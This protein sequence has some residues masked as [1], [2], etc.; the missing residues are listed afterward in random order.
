MTKVIPLTPGRIIHFHASEHDGIARLNGQPLPAMIAGIHNDRLVNLSVCD[1]YGNWQPRSSV[2]F[3]QPGD[4]K[5]DHAHATWMEYQIGQAAKTEQLEQQLQG[6][7]GPFAETDGASASETG[8]VG[9]S[10]EGDTTGA[11][12][13]TDDDTNASEGAKEPQA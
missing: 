7:N 5:P 10:N 1:A 12:E 13:A 9:A 3:V 2:V 8:L 11:I 6:G 4:N